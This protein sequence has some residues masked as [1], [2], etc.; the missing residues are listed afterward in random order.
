MEKIKSKSKITI[1][2]MVAAV[3]QSSRPATFLNPDYPTASMVIVIV[4]GHDGL[5]LRRRIFG[6]RL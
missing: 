1:K 2:K 5:Q 3:I 6:A 4:P